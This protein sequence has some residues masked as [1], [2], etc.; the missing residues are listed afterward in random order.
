M[1]GYRAFGSDAISVSLKGVVVLG[2]FMA[3]DLRTYALAAVRSHGV[4]FGLTTFA[5]DRKF[6]S[7][8]HREIGPG[9]RNTIHAVLMSA[10]PA[11]DE[12]L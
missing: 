5:P 3:H 11:L 12:N 2:I 9:R 7:A 1:K 8:K 10:F 6:G 4:H